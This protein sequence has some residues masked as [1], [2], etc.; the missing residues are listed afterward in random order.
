MVV[1]FWLNAVLRSAVW[2]GA[3]ALLAYLKKP[4]GAS[5]AAVRTD[6]IGWLGLGLL[7]VG[8]SLHFWSNVTLAR[9]EHAS[10]HGVNTL[11]TNGPYAFVRHPIYLAGIPLL[12][13][14]C[15]LYATLTG[16]DLVGGLV[17]VTY[18]HIRVV[19]V[20]EPSLRRQF[21]VSYEE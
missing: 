5:L 12:T 15:L 13:G 6:A 21:G 19:R 1:P 20:E 16:A 4:A 3:A 9:G 10:S 11:V 17:G 2:L 8:L 14:T 18:F 7:V